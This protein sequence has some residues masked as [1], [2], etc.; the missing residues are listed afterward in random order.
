MLHL[1]NVKNVDGCYTKFA[2]NFN[3]DQKIPKLY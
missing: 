2:A 1:D 3:S